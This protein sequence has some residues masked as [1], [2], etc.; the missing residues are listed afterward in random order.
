MIIQNPTQFYHFCK[1]YNLP[2]SNLISCMDEYQ[3]LCVCDDP[4]VKNDKY[5]QCC[6]LYVAIV[7]SGEFS[8]SIVKC[9]EKNIQFFNKGNLIKIF[10]F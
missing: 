1:K 8:N 4:R 10:K 6:S 7:N 3:V 9:G 5:E 2:Y